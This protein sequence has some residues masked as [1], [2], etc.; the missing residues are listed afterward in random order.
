MY[1]IY[2]LEVPDCK[3]SIFVDST[4]NK[5]LHVCLLVLSTREFLVDDSH[6]FQRLQ[7]LKKLVSI[8]ENA[9]CMINLIVSYIY[10]IYIQYIYIYIYIYYVYL[11]FTY[12]SYILFV[13]ILYM[14]DENIFHFLETTL[15]LRIYYI[16]CSIGQVVSSLDSMKIVCRMGM[17]ISANFG[18]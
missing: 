16:C 2:S 11:Y 14:W 13:F 12:I 3:V 8:R 7:N 1:L 9:K 15:F 10:Y 18:I 17:G 4:V 6:H 5:I